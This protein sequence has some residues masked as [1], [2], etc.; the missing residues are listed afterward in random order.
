MSTNSVIDDRI[1]KLNA[2]RDVINSRIIRIQTI[3][4]ETL[5]R[6]EAQARELSMLGSSVESL[7]SDIQSL[8]REL[9]TLCDDQ[10]RTIAETEAELS[11]VERALQ[12]LDAPPAPT[13]HSS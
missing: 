4:E 2:Q 11:V 9:S 10:E 12:A 3:R 5:K 8:E 13:T 1:K 7:D 6:Q